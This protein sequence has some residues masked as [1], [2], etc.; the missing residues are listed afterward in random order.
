MAIRATHNRW[1][2]RGILPEKHR[3]TARYT[4]PRRSSMLRVSHPELHPVFEA[5][6]YGAGFLAYY[7]ARNR[8]GD[9]L[10]DDQ[11]WSLIAAAAIG[12]VLG[13]RLLG[14]LQNA[15]IAGFHWRELLAPGGKTI[16]GGLLGGWIAIEITKLFLAI[17][18]RTG[19][20]FAVPLCI[21][22]AVGRIGCF[23]AGIAD[24]TYGRVT[25]LPW[26][27]DFGDGLPRHPTQL[28]E[29]AFLAGLGWILWR[30]DKRPHKPGAVF[31][32]FLA[33]YLGWRL[34]TDFLKPQPLLAG[35]SVIQW[36]C[37]AGLLALG[38]G[39]LLKEREQLRA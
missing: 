4:W 38:A 39:K 13:S 6:G 10:R 29:I 30:W 26:G 7:R 36:S 25:T 16:V 22:I 1:T 37:L 17:H 2:D 23:L 9:P 35:M 18:L 28:Y 34:V 11:R 33:S 8:V 19:D 32:T 21:G 3:P 27:A 20:L 14:L 12:A 5:L 24:D 31:R 15:P